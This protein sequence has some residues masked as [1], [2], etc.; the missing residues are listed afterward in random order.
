MAFKMHCCGDA[1][2]D[3]GHCSARHYTCRE[4]AAC[5]GGFQTLFLLTSLYQTFRR[6]L[7][8]TVVVTV[9][10]TTGAKNHMH[11][12]GGRKAPESLFYHFFYAVF[13]HSN[14]HVKAPRSL[15][16]IL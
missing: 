7:M 13:P 15:V 4:V 10:L 3:R 11:L 5:Q 8:V 16:T 14:K 1:K 9:W 6:L 12:R 2:L